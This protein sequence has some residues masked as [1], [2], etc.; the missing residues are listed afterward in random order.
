MNTRGLKFTLNRKEDWNFNLSYIQGFLTEDDKLILKGTESLSNGYFFTKAFNSGETENSWNR[1]KIN[2][3]FPENVFLRVIVYALDEIINKK[4]A[5]VRYM[6][7]ILGDKTLSSEKKQSFLRDNGAII[8]EKCTDIYLTDMKGQYLFLAIEVQNY[9]GQDCII[10]EFQIEFSNSSF[11]GFLPE[12]YSICRGQNNFFERFVGIY[13][14]MYM[15]M[16][17]KIEN[18]PI[19]FSPSKVDKKFLYWLA[20][21]FSLKDAAIWGEDRLRNVLREIVNL[22]KLKG[23]RGTISRIVELYTGYTPYIIEKHDIE[24]TELYDHMTKDI[25]ELYGENVYYFTVVVS[26]KAVKSSEDYVSLI[27]II[28]RFKP[29][30]AVC[31]LVVLNPNM[32]VGHHCYLGINSRVVECTDM[33]IEC[34]SVLEGNEYVM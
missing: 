22:Y 18:I 8:F 21:W 1:L 23:T 24:E 20:D 14:S 31:N 13:Q 3:N 26:E 6:E 29:I 25:D 30:D 28:N 17:N 2:A 10:N 34:Q 19:L 32:H 4:N 16:N 11:V 5:S 33:T 7:S 15:D 9:S 12:M 27:K